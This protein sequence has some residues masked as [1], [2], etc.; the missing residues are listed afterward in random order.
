MSTETPFQQ[1]MRLLLSFR[2]EMEKDHFRSIMLGWFA[3]NAP[4]DL[5]RDEQ[6]SGER[7]HHRSLPTLEIA[8]LGESKLFLSSTSCQKVCVYLHPSL[9]C[10][11][12]DPST[13]DTD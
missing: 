2:T 5:F 3:Q 12:P 9:L 11:R 8:I 10:Y 4:D 13:S 6:L 7:I 1:Y